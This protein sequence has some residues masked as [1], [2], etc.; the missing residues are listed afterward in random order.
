MFKEKFLKNLEKIISFQSVSGNIKEIEKTLDF[1]KS[2]FVEKKVEI[3]EFEK[4]NVKSL[5]ISNQKILDFDVL[6]VTH[7][8]VVAASADQFKLRI[9]GDKLF[10]R[11]TGDDKGPA[12]IGAMIA[13][14]ILEKKQDKKI[15]FLFATD[16]EVGSENGVDYLINELG[17]KA[18]VVLL[19]DG[20]EDHQLIQAC[21]GFLHCEIKAVGKEAHGSQPW[22]GDNAIEKL[23]NVFIELK[24]LFADDI[25]EENY[26]QN[27]FN[28]GMFNGGKATNQVPAEAKMD[29]DIRYVDEE[30]R[31]KI[32]SKFVE[33]EKRILGV[34]INFQQGEMMFLNLDSEYVK[35][36][37]KIAKEILGRELVI[38]KETGATDGRHFSAQGMDVLTFAPKMA[39]IHG[40]DEWLSLS[41]AGDYY[42]IAKKFIE[43]L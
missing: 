26:W 28:L 29:L 39:N 9:A 16:E 41:S 33:I 11:G 17:L 6:Y 13:Q 7:L 30:S 42:Q 3:Q 25:S 34:K 37:Q 12:L 1:V 27:S 38:T 32:K 22:F 31:E 8:D 23:I 4:N 20:G 36:V 14:D 2:F 21:K 19:P 43:D 10:G 24:K 35:K 40:A 5:L 18:K 15:G